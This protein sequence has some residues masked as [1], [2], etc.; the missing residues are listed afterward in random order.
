[1]NNRQYN[2]IV[3]NSRRK[4]LTLNK[5]RLSDTISL[6]RAV[7]SDI[8]AEAA[9][10]SDDDGKLRKEQL[11]EM[12]SRID[13]DLDVFQDQFD[14]IVKTG[15]SDMAS[16]IIE[17]NGEIFLEVEGTKKLID[18]LQD[19][20]VMQAI[21]LPEKDGLILS[22]RVWRTSQEAKMDIIRRLQQGMLLGESHA[23]VARDIKQYIES[24]PLRYKSERLVT[25]EMAKAYQR[26]NAASVEVMRQNSQYMWFEKWELSPRHPRPDV[27]DIL[28]SQDLDGEGAGVY[29]QSPNR[30]PGCLCYIYP[31]YRAKREKG[32]YPSVSEVAPDI[33]ELPPSQK[34]LAKELSN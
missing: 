32:D 29:K 8:E 15:I 4:E 26:A 18:I 14:A 21:T 25:T 12:K 28:A 3:H 7:S 2:Q 27:C 34:K 19:K 11:R 23:K 16:V 22:D 30:H 17:R 9:K 5:E 24:G 13:E 10:L 1:M 20:I 6:L 31:V 33:S